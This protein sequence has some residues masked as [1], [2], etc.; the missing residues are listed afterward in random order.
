M[1]R[2]QILD[3]VNKNYGTISEHLWEKYPKYEV[4]RHFSN[5][6]WY[7]VIMNI[8]KSKIGFKG[9]SLIDILVLKGNPDDIVHIT[10]MNGFAPA[11]H[12]NKKHW[13]TIVLDENLNEEVV[14]Q[15]IDKSYNLTKKT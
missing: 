10:E 7:G 11:Y 2:L 12:M 15:M 6:K 9:D 3:Y 8:P 13:Y 14:F 4:L 5:K 1:T